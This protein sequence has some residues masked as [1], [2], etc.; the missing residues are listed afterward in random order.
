MEISNALLWV[1]HWLIKLVGNRC[2][3]LTVQ[4]VRPANVGVDII[5]TKNLAEGLK[6]DRAH[7]KAC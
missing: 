7:G 2:Y 3:H 4:R 6:K 1:V 5:A